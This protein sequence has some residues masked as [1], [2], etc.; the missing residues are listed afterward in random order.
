ML[1]IN[2]RELIRSVVIRFGRILASLATP[3]SVQLSNIIQRSIKGKAMLVS[4]L[5]APKNNIKQGLYLR[6]NGEIAS[7]SRL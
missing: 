1:L 3:L 5:I 7:V 2:L 6:D 4:K